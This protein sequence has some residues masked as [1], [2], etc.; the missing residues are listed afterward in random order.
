MFVTDWE[1][2][3]ARGL[4]DFAV[5]QLHSFPCG[6]IHFNFKQIKQDQKKI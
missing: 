6:D 1:Y 5:A 4:I 3:A 2:E